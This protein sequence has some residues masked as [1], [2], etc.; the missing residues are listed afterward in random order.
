VSN[1]R[2]IPSETEGPVADGLGLASRLR[3]ALPGLSNSKRRIAEA[4]LAD[5][6][7]PVHLSLY[8][9]AGRLGISGATL[10]RF[11]QEVGYDGYR[12]L[13]LVAA[14]EQGKKESNQ[15]WSGEKETSRKD[16]AT[17][18]K[19]IRDELL[20]TWVAALQAVAEIVDL[21]SLDA[22]AKRMSDAARIDIYGI[23]TS[24]FV[25]M[26]AAE[27][28]RGLGLDATAW[29]EV[30]RGMQ[31][32]A[33]LDKRSVAMAIS[34]S[35]KTYETVEM[36]ATA[37]LAGAFCVAMTSRPASPLA[38]TGDAVIEMFMPVESVVNRA[39]S[40][41]GTQLFV[42]DM[43]GRLIVRHNP[44]REARVQKLMDEA[45]ARHSIG[46]PR[47]PP[48]LANDQRR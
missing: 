21:T 1:H 41:E 3:A 48:W 44:R 15:L 10:V 36:L 33:R 37:R 19:A 13:R 23:G 12:E 16:A 22:V 20:R 14:T 39:V 29:T 43:L 45:V 2:P 26:G 31:A 17:T 38:E 46:Q 6:E 47:V 7:I 18:P 40:A 28:L 4:I 35:G 25:G 27:R 9:L 30:H 8:Q 32:A 34:V 5:P 42:L 24:G 11:C